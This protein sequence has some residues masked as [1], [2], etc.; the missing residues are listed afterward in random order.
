MWSFQY[1]MNLAQ[2]NVARA[3]A[4][5][6]LQLREASVQGRAYNSY[7]VAVRMP[8]CAFIKTCH[9][10][11]IAKACQGFQRKAHFAQYVLESNLSKITLRIIFDIIFGANLPKNLAA[12]APF[13]A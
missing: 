13:P 10:S 6:D 7:D 3:C 9:K 2:L 1:L 8:L 4:F 11:C 12:P 5:P